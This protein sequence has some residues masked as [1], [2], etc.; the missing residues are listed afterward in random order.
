MFGRKKAVE[1][2]Y[3]IAVKNYDD[4]LKLL[5]EGTISLSG[6][7]TVYLKLLSSQSMKVNNKK[8]LRKFIK[9]NKKSVKE[10]IHYWESLILDGYTLMNVE[11]L[12][13]RPSIDHI[14]N[15]ET[16]KY[17]TAV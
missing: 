6:N 13:K 17:V 9:A 5:K 15:N 10:V 16:I 12:E 8:E 3:I 2:R 11:Y 7:K 14:C 1:N 4:T